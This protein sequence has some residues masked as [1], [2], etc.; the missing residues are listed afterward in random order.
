MGFHNFELNW[1][2]IFRECKVSRY[3]HLKKYKIHIFF[4]F[5]NILNL[6]VLNHCNI[7][8]KFSSLLSLLL[9]ELGFWSISRNLQPIKESKI[10]KTKNSRFFL[11]IYKNSR[12]SVTFTQCGKKKFREINDLVKKL[13][14]TNFFVRKVWEG[15][16]VISTLCFTFAKV[17]W[18]QFLIGLKKHELYPY[19]HFHGNFFPDWKVRYDKKLMKATQLS[20][21]WKN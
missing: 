21:V 14:S 6:K 3:I 10:K 8:E 4:K 17:T 16:S 20:T 12:D 18:N 9:L 5:L 13:Q 2:V 15:V 19:M 1:K 7:F 11:T